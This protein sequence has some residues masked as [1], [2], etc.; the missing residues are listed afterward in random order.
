M[1]STKGQNRYPCA[2]TQEQ[3]SIIVEAF[4][5]W[6]AEQTQETKEIVRLHIYNLRAALAPR[7]VMFGESAAK[8][9]IA[10]V[11]LEVGKFN[12]GVAV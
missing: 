2:I 1:R 12:V 11:Y 7:K 4:D 9:L 6:L 8:V 5:A 10:A 3:E